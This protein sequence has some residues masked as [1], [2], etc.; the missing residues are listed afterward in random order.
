MSLLRLV[1]AIA[2]LGG[3]ATA[4][5]GPN[6]FG[7]N[8]RQITDPESVI[9]LINRN[10]LPVAVE[11]LYITRLIDG[12]ALSP[13]GTEVAITTNLTGRTNLWKVPTT[14]S[15][16]VQLVNADDRQTEPRWSPDGRWIAYSQDKGGNELWDIYVTAREGG[17][18]TNLTNTPDIREQHPVWSRDAKLI[19]CAYKP[20]TAPSYDLAVVDVATHQLRRLTEEKDPQ[21]SWDV[22]A[23][24]PDGRTLYGN[25]T[26]PAGDDGDVYAVDVA[27]GRQTNLTPHEGKQLNIGTDVSSDGKVLLMTSN[28]KA[29]YPNAALLDT[30]TRKLAWAT[31][32]QWEVTSG[33]FSPDG[34]HFTYAVNADGRTALYLAEHRSL[35]ATELKLPLGVN[36]IVS[37]QHFS[38]D[39]RQILIQHEAIN[40]PNDLWIFDVG[41][42]RTRQLTH[43]AVASLTPQTLPPSQLVHYASFDKKIIT[44]VLQMPFNLKRDR[45]NPA[46]ILPHGGPTWQ[47]SDYWNRWANALATR[48]YIVLMP[49][50]RGS[51]GYGIEFQSANYQ[52]LGG[53]D[54]KDEMHGLEWLLSTGYVDPGKVGVFGG[55]YGG[56]MTLMLAA[57]EPTRFAAAV[58]LYGPLDFFSMLKHADPSLGAYVKSLL[59]DPEKDRKV[60]EVSSPITYVHGI[61]APLLVLQG[62]NDPRIPKEE[63]ER[64]V[65]MLKKRGNVVD[66]VYYPSEGH[67]FDKVENQIDA[68]RRIVAWFDKYLKNA[69]S[70]PAATK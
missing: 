66:V 29:G 20:A 38:P 39:G 58:D 41:T 69:S 14:G 68:A 67:G 33:A 56:F 11:D 19:A 65:E 64:L 26:N 42:Q 7:P 35:K 61:R 48:G 30:A 9:S 12:A 50:P 47:M 22:I 57:K 37:P 18:P 10:A 55:S 60:Y 28:R 62:D 21:R 54:L 32:T 27:S 23:F 46:I 59:G 15:W 1:V 16:P 63:S 70:T 6:T 2:A 49:N 53:G 8:A 5:A 34:K 44:A 25:R 31:D 13:D 4:T 52:D 36:T 3:M 51:T 24:S 17:S 45:S 40:T 43:M